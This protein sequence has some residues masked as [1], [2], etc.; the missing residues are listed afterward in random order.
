MKLI[1]EIMNFINKFFGFFKV[2]NGEMH[3]YNDDLGYGTFEDARH[4]WWI[5]IV[6]VL[7]I[8]MYQYCKKNKE[9]G[10]KLVK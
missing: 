5:A 6:I 2:A 4:I 10:K 9:K 8:V 3:P 1:T 7:S